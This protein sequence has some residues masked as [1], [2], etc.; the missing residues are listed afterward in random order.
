MTGSRMLRV[1][2]R[3]QEN[4][5]QG[6]LLSAIKYLGVAWGSCLECN[7]SFTF[8][9]LSLDYLPYQKAWQWKDCEERRRLEMV[10][11]Q[12]TPDPLNARI[13]S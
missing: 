5:R 3:M 13:I 11:C 12:H 8:W 10:G 6:S 1:V 7:V 9:P 4:Q 2:D